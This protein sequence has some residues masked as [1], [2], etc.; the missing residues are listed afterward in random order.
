MSQKIIELP[1][2]GSVR[3]VKSSRNRNLRL[4]VDAKGVRVS[5]PQWTPYAAGSAYALQHMAWIKRHQENTPTVRILADGD[6]IGRMHSLHFQSVPTV[7]RTQVRLTASKIIVQYHPTEQATD[8]AVQARALRGTER[9]LKK[10]ADAVLP[11]RLQ[12][13]AKQHGFEYGSV[14][15]KRLQRRW[16]SCDSNRH[17]ILNY[18]L[19]ELPWDCID[20][21][22]LHELTH[23]VHLHHGP[24]FW[25]HMKNVFPRVADVRT[26]LRQYQPM[27]RSVS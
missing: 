3:L 16:G 17:I 1:G 2:I 6:R 27:L 10:E 12:A 20:Y 7:Q 13:L 11:P 5:M 4:T 26:Q 18:Y 9:A 23:T 22:L 21:V 24:D 25:A 15:T 14:S 8:P 19:M